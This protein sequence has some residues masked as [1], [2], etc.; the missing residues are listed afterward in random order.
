MSKKERK[1]PN[2]L[3]T[4]H[5]HCKDE[6]NEGI[7]CLPSGKGHLSSN[8]FMDK[9]HTWHAWHQQLGAS[10]NFHT[11]LEIMRGNLLTCL[12]IVSLLM[13]QLK[14]WASVCRQKKLAKMAHSKLRKKSNSEKCTFIN[15]KHFASLQSSIAVWSGVIFAVRKVLSICGKKKVV[16][17]RSGV[18]GFFF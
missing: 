2:G 5:F 12:T 16:L 7:F 3:E 6:M 18:T 1:N 10:G 17:V 9:V 14:V 15:I 4:Q 11:N 13:H 8:L